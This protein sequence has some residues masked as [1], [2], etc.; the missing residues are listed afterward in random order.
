[1]TVELSNDAWKDSLSFL[2][3]KGLFVKWEGIWPTFTKFRN[4]CD[5][6]WGE[7]MDLKISGNGYYL[8][9][10]P[11]AQDRD[12]IIENDRF[13]IEG[14]GLNISAWT[15][16]FNLCEASIEKTLIWIKLQGLP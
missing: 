16:N 8:V 11:T 3:D 7:G 14:R 6:N 10:C 4:W 5:K 9:I 1:M 12:W 2:S 13:F 15:P